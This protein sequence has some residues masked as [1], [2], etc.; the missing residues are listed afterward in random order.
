MGTP[1]VILS[2]G[3]RGPKHVWFSSLTLIVLGTLKGIRNTKR[4]PAFK[5]LTVWH[6][7]LTEM[8][9]KLP[10]ESFLKVP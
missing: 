5:T 10:G 8:G 7:R 6:S 2:I 9:D 1:L 3:V 4:V